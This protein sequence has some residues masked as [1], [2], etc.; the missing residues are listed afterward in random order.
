MTD[1]VSPEAKAAM[2]GRIAMKRLGTVDD[3]AYAVVFLASEQAGYMTGTVLNI[4]GGLY[5]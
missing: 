5:T 2:E 1:A 3:V 4:S